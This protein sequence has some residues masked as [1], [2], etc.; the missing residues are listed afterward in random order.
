MRLVGIPRFLIKLGLVGLWFRLVGIPRI[1]KYSWETNAEILRVAGAKIGKKNVR[2]LSPV[3][4][5]RRSLDRNYSNLTIAD[6]C[7]LNGN[8]FI[9]V[10]ARVTM[11]EGVSLGPGVIIMSH[12]S[13]NGNEFLKDR[14]S[15]TCGCK[16]VL[17]KKGA[18]IKAGA[19][20]AMGVTIG[21]NAVIGGQAIVNRDIPANS[22][23]VGTPA[24]V[25]NEIK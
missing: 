5:H 14:L 17:I 24:K 15:H 16:D 21:E 23:A 4:L 7:V 22:F 25:T 13:Y 2:I 11:E 9:D 18:G 6:H 8:N 10:S 1:L 3:T 20:V 12:N 19:V